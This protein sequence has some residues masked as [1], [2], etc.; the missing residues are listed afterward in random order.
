MRVLSN[1]G[2]QQAGIGNSHIWISHNGGLLLAFHAT[3]NLGRIYAGRAVLLI[4]HRFWGNSTP[5]EVQSTKNLQFLGLDQAISDFVRFARA[6]ELP[7]N[8]NGSSN[9]REAPWIWTGGFYPGALGAWIESIA[10][11]TFW[12][13]HSSGGSV[14]VIYDYW[15]YFYAIQQ[16]MPKN[17]SKDFAAIVDHIDMV[18]TKGSH[19]EQADLKQLFGPQ[20]LEPVDDVAARATH[21][22]GVGLKKALPNFAKWYRAKYLPGYNT[23]RNTFDRQ[24]VWLRCNYP[25]FY[26]QTGAP[27]NRPTIFTRLANTDYY[28]R[29]YDLFFPKEG[30]YTYGSAS[31]KRADTINAHTNGWNLPSHLDEGSRLLFV[32]SE[33]D[34]WRPASVASEFRPSGPLV[35]TH[36]VPSIII[37]GS[38]H[39]DDLRVMNAAN[40][41][42]RK[43]QADIVAQIAKWTNEFYT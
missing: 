13:T 2:L 12:A 39:C 33:L 7:F 41:D 27:A 38:R 31:G 20:D 29:Q 5:Y 21:S 24:W 35:S 19:K 34:P 10:P 23:W 43:A 36:D 17:C 9:A 42:V 14:E 30:S 4:E 8:T 6:V 28:Q 32:N 40:E 16:G 3:D 15:Q 22:Y 11:G 1:A 26:Y 37:P 18:F 25:L